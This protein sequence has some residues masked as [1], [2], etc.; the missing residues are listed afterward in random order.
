MESN[1]SQKKLAPKY[2]AYLVLGRKMFQVRWV[3]GEI[4]EFQ[5][6]GNR[7]LKLKMVLWHCNNKSKLDEHKFIEIQA[8]IYR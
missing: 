8:L 7:K 3:F 1:D 2:K 4:P 5:E 6:I